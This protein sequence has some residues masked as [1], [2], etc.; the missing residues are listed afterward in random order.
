[1]LIIR[2]TKKTMIFPI[3]IEKIPNIRRTGII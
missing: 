2:R 3:M 1:M